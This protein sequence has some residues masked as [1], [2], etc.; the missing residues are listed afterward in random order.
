M[1][2]RVLQAELVALDAQ[3]NWLEGNQC[4]S[5]ELE[6]R[7]SA[8]SELVIPATTRDALD[9]VIAQRLGRCSRKSHGVGR[10]GELTRGQPVPDIEAGDPGLLEG[11]QYRASEPA[12]PAAGANAGN[13]P[14][15]PQ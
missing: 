5:I 11:K 7:V 6:T 12:I 2:F 1:V 15:P 9:A 8:T 14:N 10:V 4:R 3:G 13:I